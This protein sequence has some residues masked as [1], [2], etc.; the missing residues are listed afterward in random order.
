MIFKEIIATQFEIMTVYSE[1]H[2][3]ILGKI[4]SYVKVVGSYI[5]QWVLE[6]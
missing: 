3:Q 5:Y 2:I 6:A 4:R 1:N